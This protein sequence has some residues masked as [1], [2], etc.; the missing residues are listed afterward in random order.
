MQLFDPFLKMKAESVDD[1]ERIR[2]ASENRLRQ[3]TRDTVDS[4]G[5]ER[6][7][8]LTLDH[9]DVAIQ[10][11]VVEGLVTL[12][13]QA[14]RGLEQ[15]LK[16]HALGPW[17][18]HPSQKGIGLKMAARLLST[19]GDPYWNTLYDRPRKLSELW[20][21]CGHGSASVKRKGQQV[22]WSPEAKMRV[23]LIAVSIL[24]VGA[25]D[26]RQVYYD[27]KAETEGRPHA[28]V[29][30]RC[31]PSGKPA[32]IGSPWSDGHRHA[33]ALRILGREFLRDLWLEAKRLHE[34]D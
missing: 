12:E 11:G 19:V 34:E 10:A 7:Y 14:I 1:L 33:D 3:L 9:P 24:K 4:D 29:C 13:K 18:Q 2:I 16:K 32:Q 15:A 6:G 20:Q 23:Y 26:L 30:V 27:R 5:E 31:G 8:G 22:F 21:Y 25:P 28:V 17:I